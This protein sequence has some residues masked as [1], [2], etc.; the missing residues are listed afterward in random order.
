LLGLSRA[1]ALVSRGALYLSGIGLVAM[2]VTVTWQVFSRYVLNDSPSWTEA[3]SIQMMSWFIFLGAAVG[4]RER[5]HLGFDVLLYIMPPSAKVWLRMLADIAVLVF[6][7][8]MVGYGMQLIVQTWSARIP[9]LGLPGGF[10]YMP[11][12][13]GGVLM[14][15]FVLERIVLRLLGVDVDTLADEVSSHV[16]EAQ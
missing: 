4:V 15:I 8:G 16:S 10:N 14:V 11:V 3:T 7:C 9:V 6:A 12:F 5:F 2:T 13:T 1:L